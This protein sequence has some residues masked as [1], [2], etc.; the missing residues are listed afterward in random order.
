MIALKVF[1][2]KIIVVYHNVKLTET[3]TMQILHD[4]LT[5]LTC[6]KTYTDLYPETVFSVKN[7]RG[8]RNSNKAHYSSLVKR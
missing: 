5:F 2:K 6:H 7:E 1:V 3:N 4:C 8:S